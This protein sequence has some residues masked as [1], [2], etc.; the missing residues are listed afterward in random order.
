MRLIGVTVSVALLL[1]A[2]WSQ[3]PAPQAP[4]PSMEPAIV[5]GV[6][7]V[8]EGGTPAVEVLS[9]HQVVPTIQMLD[10][11]PRLVI[12]LAN[13][14]IGLK[15]KRIPVL[16]EDF[17]TLRTEQYQNEPPIVRVVLD[18]LVPY[19]Y[20]W[21]IAD[22]RLMVRLRPIAAPPKNASAANKASPTRPARTFSLAAANTGTMPVSNGIGEIVMADRQLP[23]TSPLTAGNDTLVLR[24]A[25]GGEVHICPGTTI[26]V[27]PAKKSND[28][29]LGM[30][31]G[32]LE[33]HYDLGAASD[34]VLTPDFRILFAGP[35]E[36]DF[37]VSADSRG[38]TCVRGLP[39]N[40]SSAIVSELIGNRTYQVKS[41]AQVLFHSGQID[42]V[43]NN[44]P[45][46]CGCPQSVPVIRTDINPAQT[47]P[48]SEPATNSALAKNAPPEDVAKGPETRPLPPSQPN[49]VHIQVEVP[50]VFQG[51]KSAGSSAPGQEAASR[52]PESSSQAVRQEPPLAPPAA[53]PQNQAPAPSAP[54][55]FLRRIKNLFGSIF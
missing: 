32:A 31:T 26:S 22:N 42:K 11:P 44:V 28:L 17:L 30:S 24:L 54:R 51:K 21:D 15:E 23:A 29:M 16:Q 40:T 19:S 9:T 3:K 37:A 52:P 8:R 45:A 36:F 48:A 25:R 50:M 43:D 35:G 5:T 49:D 46:D 39:G 13:A 6:Q 10:S 41:G 20:T 14:R 55:R 7:I 12:D 47:A 4:A 53:A 34:S 27:T 33:T 18:L 38:N 2:A 1:S